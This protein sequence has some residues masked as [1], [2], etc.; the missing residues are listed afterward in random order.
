MCYCL[1]QCRM[2]A[3]VEQALII[4][5][6]SPVFLMTWNGGGFWLLPKIPKP[7]KNKE[8]EQRYHQRERWLAC[9]SPLA[10]FNY[11]YDAQLLVKHQYREEGSTANIF[12]HTAME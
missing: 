12:G 10:L 3:L 5:M 1:P 11:G 7:M 9:R 8:G 6:L 4:G 2:M